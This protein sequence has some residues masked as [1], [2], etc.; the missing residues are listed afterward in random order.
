LFRATAAA[1]EQR[2]RKR[3]VGVFF[4]SIKDRS[5]RESLR[6]WTPYSLLSE[7]MRGLSENVP[8]EINRGLSP[9]VISIV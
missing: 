2:L 8:A 3:A 5:A 1:K 9:V 6:A 7:F 4:F